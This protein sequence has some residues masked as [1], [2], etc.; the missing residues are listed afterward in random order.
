M[1]RICALFI[2][3]PRS[4]SHLHIPVEVLLWLRPDLARKLL[5]SHRRLFA[6]ATGRAHRCTLESYEEKAQGKG[7][8]RLFRILL[9]AK[10]VERAAHASSHQTLSPGHLLPKKHKLKTK[11]DRQKSSIEEG[12]S[13]G[14]TEEWPEALRITETC[15]SCIDTFCAR[16]GQR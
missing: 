13:R 5:R 8:R 11:T 3:V 1:K 14:E 16:H 4:T 10:A 2:V 9:I 12:F 7:N 6:A 15:Y